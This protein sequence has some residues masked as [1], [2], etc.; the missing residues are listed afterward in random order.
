MP[1]SIR[2]LNITAEQR[3]AFKSVLSRPAAAQRD[4]RRAVIVLRRA[5]G[6]SQAETALEVSV[7]RATVIK[8]ER[9]FRAAGLAGLADAKG[10]GRKPRIAPQVSER[11][12]LEATRPP[13]NRTRWS[14]RS[15]AEAAGVSKATV[16]RLWQANDIKPHATR[17]FKLSSDKHFEKKFWDVVGLY[18]I[19]PDRA[20]VLCCDEN[21]MPGPGAQP[22]RLSRHAR[23]HPHADPRLQAPRHRLAVRRCRIWTARYSAAPPPG[24]RT[25]SG[26]TSCAS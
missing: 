1:Q 21:S 14:V 20:L 7:S 11:I 13:S 25:G 26:W 4:R 9:R 22:A 17:T 23:I 18:L 2:A 8:W 15:M 5:D 16:Q 10:Q 24:T 12:I 19:P 3:R 6:L